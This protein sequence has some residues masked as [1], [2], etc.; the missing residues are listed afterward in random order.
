M[1]GLL[2][3]V[4]KILAFQNKIDSRGK[5]KLANENIKKKKQKDGIIVT[6]LYNKNITGFVTSYNIP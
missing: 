2:E 3:R 4:Q 1:E 5:P 6:N